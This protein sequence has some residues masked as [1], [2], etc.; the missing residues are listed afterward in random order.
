MGLFIVV[1]DIP[2]CQRPRDAGRTFQCVPFKG[3]QDVGWNTNSRS[4]EEKR[5]NGYVRA[6]YNYLLG[7]VLPH[8]VEWV[9][10]QG[11]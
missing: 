4:R 1:G 5:V 9:Q 8:G 6:L 3:D 2:S 11:M 10:V 7:N